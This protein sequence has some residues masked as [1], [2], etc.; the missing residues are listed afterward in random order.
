MQ[1]RHFFYASG[2]LDPQ[3]A[4]DVLSLCAYHLMAAID[5]FCLYVLTI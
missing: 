1:E 4:I 2:K 5:M 3:L